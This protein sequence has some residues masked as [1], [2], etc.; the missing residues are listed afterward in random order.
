MEADQALQQMAFYKTRYP[1]YILRT[2]RSLTFRAAPDAREIELL[3]AMAFEAM[4]S[5]DRAR[6][7]GA[8]EADAPVKDD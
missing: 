3:R 6:R 4:R 1:E 7:E 2:M 5:I 8:S